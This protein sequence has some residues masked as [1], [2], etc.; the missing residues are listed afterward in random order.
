M[1]EPNAADVSGTISIDAVGR[2]KARQSNSTRFRSSL[3]R[4]LESITLQC[5][6]VT[7]KRS[8]NSAKTIE[9]DPGFYYAHWNLGRSAGNEKDQL[10]EAPRNTGKRWSLDHVPAM[11]GFVAARQ[12]ENGPEG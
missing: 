6:V 7:T 11:L 1:R 8:S 3:T 5:A 2:G 4:T 9:L 10:P 12:C